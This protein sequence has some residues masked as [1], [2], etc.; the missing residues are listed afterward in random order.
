M[1]RYFTLGL[2]GR[3]TIAL[4]LIFSVLILVNELTV[5]SVVHLTLKNVQL[6]KLMNAPEL[7]QKKNQIISGIRK[8]V[9][10]YTITAALLSLTAAS[11]AIHRIA[12]KPLRRITRALEDVTRGQ[13]NVRLPIEGARELISLSSSFNQMIETIKSQRDELENR[14]LQL[15]DTTHHLQSTQ[16]D[17]IRAAKLASVGTLASGVAHE[18]GNPITGILGLLEALETETNVAKSHSYK[19]LIKN[20]IERI[21]KTIR[22]LLSYA[23]PKAQ[24]EAAETEIHPVLRN[25]SDLVRVQKTFTQIELVLPEDTTFPKLSI[26]HDDLTAVLVNLLLNAAQAIN[27]KGKIEI[28]YE[29]KQQPNN[30]NPPIETAVI[31]IRDNGPGVPNEIVDRIFDP[32]FTS[33]NTGDGSG[34]GLAICQ[35]ICERNNGRIELIDENQSG[36]HFQVTIPT[37]SF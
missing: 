32:F 23:R 22:G 17:L 19:R 2:I 36:A 35:G 6:E 33:R 16:A 27:G 14:L 13:K 24:N 15:E 18:I 25:A 26:G 4:V 30:P 12:V 3:I 31:H 10:I 21:D 5:T 1:K 28:Q 8:P 11:I 34:L 37:V 29:K 9:L 20:E 7:Q